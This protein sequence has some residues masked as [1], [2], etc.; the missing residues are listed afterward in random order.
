MEVFE[1]TSAQPA[2]AVTVL[3]LAC[4]QRTYPAYDPFHATNAPM[5]WRRLSIETPG[6]TAVFEQTDYGHPGRLNAWEPRG[7]APALLPRLS[8]LQALAE[9][10]TAT[11][12]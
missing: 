11:L 7:V 1:M 2:A 9:S 3:K 4:E 12:A 10:V 6:G 8:Q 5:L